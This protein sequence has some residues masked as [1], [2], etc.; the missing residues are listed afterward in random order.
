MDDEQIRN[1]LDEFSE[2]EL[3]ELLDFVEE[4][5]GFEN[6]EAALSSLEFVSRAA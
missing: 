5:G 2:E 1:L 3:A 4:V 6:A